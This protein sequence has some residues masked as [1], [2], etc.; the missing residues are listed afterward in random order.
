MDV[1][2][3]RRASLESELFGQVDQW[4]ADQIRKL[5]VDTI[6]SG[7]F[8]CTA[9][10]EVQGDYIVVYKGETFRFDAMTTYAV[11]QFLS[12]KQAASVG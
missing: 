11:L 2:I 5:S 3:Q 12:G 10:G 7:T 6:A 4:I 9:C 8:T 1:D